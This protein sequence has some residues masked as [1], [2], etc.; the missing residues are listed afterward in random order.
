M[1]RRV[2]IERAAEWVTRRCSHEIEPGKSVLGSKSRDAWE[3]FWGEAVGGEAVG[4]V[5]DIGVR[6]DVR[7][8]GRQP[9]HGAIVCFAVCF[10]VLD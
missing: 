9:R 2:A 1:A 3:E 4:N 6:I 7:I 8:D 10:D 5:V